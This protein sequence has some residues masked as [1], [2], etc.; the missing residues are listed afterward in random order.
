V[1]P[2][3]T[4]KSRRLGSSLVELIAWLAEILV[5]FFLFIV[6]NPSPTN[7]PAPFNPGGESVYWHSEV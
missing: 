7:A 3:P 4:R 1:P 5:F 6:V 2:T